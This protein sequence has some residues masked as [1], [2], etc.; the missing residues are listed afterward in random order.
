MLRRRGLR[1]SKGFP[2][3]QGMGERK[4]G[5]HL[6]NRSF[7]AL[8]TC[9]H[10]GIHPSL[11]RLIRA[12]RPVA[13]ATPNEEPR[14]ATVMNTLNGIESRSH[15]SQRTTVA[16]EPAFDHA[17]ARDSYAHTTEESARAAVDALLDHVL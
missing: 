14:G 5:D 17:N 1:G 13:A 2:P 4:W 3:R 12:G 15:Q 16:I 11:P 10:A 7:G 9:G 6:C 8:P